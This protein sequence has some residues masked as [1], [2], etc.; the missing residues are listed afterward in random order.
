MQK[1]IIIGCPGSGKSTF[2]RKLSAATSL[3]LYHLDLIWHRPDKST[4]SKEK[5]D[6]R[7]AEIIA[8]DFWII[9]GN[10]Q[11]TIETR[12]QTADTIFLLDFPINVCL[13]GAKSRV[14]TKRPDMPWIE[15]ELDPEFEKL[16]MQFRETK[17]PKIY[18]LLNHHKDNKT[19]YILKSR[20]ETDAFIEKIGGCAYD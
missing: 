11:R 16:I 20:E 10:F 13:D 19:I 6:Q 7:L 5:F 8:K 17:L 14:G 18:E 15:E 12:I 9:D 2:A 1:V 3:P 4:I